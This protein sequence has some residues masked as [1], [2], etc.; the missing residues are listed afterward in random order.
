MNESLPKS[1]GIASEL[2]QEE[3]F[4]AFDFLFMSFQSELNDI[5][6]N[7]S[8]VI[9]FVLDVH[10]ASF[11]GISR[12][13]EETFDAHTTTPSVGDIPSTS[14]HSSYPNLDFS[15]PICI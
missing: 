9:H 10:E 2:L 8:D 13:L 11:D 12:I 3:F 15:T 1:H 14:I 4:E 6:A 7:N 5:E